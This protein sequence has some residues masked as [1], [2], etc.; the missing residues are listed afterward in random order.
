MPVP[1]PVHPTPLP[2]LGYVSVISITYALTCRMYR[3]AVEA[4]VEQTVR[5]CAGDHE[6]GEPRLI[7]TTTPKAMLMT[8]EISR[9]GIAQISRRALVNRLAGS[10]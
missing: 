6:G 4:E 9:A 7:S 5:L 8:I 3:S 10:S 1:V 2:H